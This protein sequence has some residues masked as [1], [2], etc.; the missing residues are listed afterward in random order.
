MKA[1]LLLLLVLGVALAA[2]PAVAF[3]DSARHLKN[4][5]TYPDSTGEDPAAPDI[6]SVVVSNDDA[7]MITFQVNISN[8]PTLTPDMSFVVFLDTDKN[9][10][11]GAAGSLGADYAIQLVPGAVDLFQWNGTTYAHAASQASLT[12]SYTATGPVIR[13]SAADLGK[14]KTFNFGV[15]ASSGDDGR[16]PGQHRQLP[17]APRLRA[18]LR[19][20]ASTATRC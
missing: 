16:R 6:T 12:F 20:T 4:T 7:G 1:R 18:R 14:S 5:T 11:T 10:T 2:M 17:G 13:V 9:G 8:R 19:A 3:G 15:V